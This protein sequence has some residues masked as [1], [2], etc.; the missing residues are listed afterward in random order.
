M[1]VT[2]IGVRQYV[3][4]VGCRCP[5]LR[6]CEVSGIVFAAKAI[7]LHIP[8]RGPCI[9]ANGCEEADWLYWKAGRKGNEWP[10]GKRSASLQEGFS[11]GVGFVGCVPKQ[12]GTN[13]K[14]GVAQP[15]QGYT[16]LLVSDVQI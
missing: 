6:E 16:E 3:Q 7:R 14:G 12:G 2:G 11:W 13:A 4:G 8:D 10:G 1:K 5:A 15:Q 9:Y